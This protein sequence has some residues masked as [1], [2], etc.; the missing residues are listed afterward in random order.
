MVPSVLSRA[1][2]EPLL[3]SAATR[4]ASS[5]GS[6]LAEA[7]AARS[8]FSS[9]AMSVMV[10]HLLCLGLTSASRLGGHRACLIGM[11]TQLGCSR[12]RFYLIDGSRVNPSSIG[13]PSH[14]T[15]GP[16][17]GNAVLA[18]STIA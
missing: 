6:S 5:A 15:E 13:K 17:P 4:T 8:S 3:P 9:C 11:A 14:D 12:V 18:F 16:Y 7:T 1:D 10:R 2:T